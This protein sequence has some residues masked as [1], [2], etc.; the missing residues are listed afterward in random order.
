MRT[1]FALAS[2]LAAT[3][4]QAHEGHGLDG[5]HLHGWDLLA[6]AAAVAAVL[7]LVLRRR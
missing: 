3:V 1:T 5:P 2:L 7:Y 6:L 4:A